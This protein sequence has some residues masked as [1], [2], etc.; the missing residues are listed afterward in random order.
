[1]LFTLQIIKI[2][3]PLFIIPAMILCPGFI[4]SSDMVIDGNYADNNASYYADLQNGS[5]IFMQP[6]IPGY[7]QVYRGCYTINGNN[8]NII[9]THKL[10]ANNT[11]EEMNKTELDLLWV[12]NY[13]LET[14]DG[15]R[16]NRLK[17]VSTNN[18]PHN[19]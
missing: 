3:F 14:Y 6:T 1:M 13:H 17:R 15:T 2:F 16:L 11:F 12:D 18:S 7:H 4:H 9:L 10:N 19:N 8:V 5:I